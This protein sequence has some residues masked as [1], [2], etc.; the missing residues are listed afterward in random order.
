MLNKIIKYFRER[1]IQS[2]IYAATLIITFSLTIVFFIWSLIFLVKL[3][4]SVVISSD[5][6]S[7]IISVFNFVD[8]AALSQKLKIVLPEEATT[9]I[10]PIEPVPEV[11]PQA[12]STPSTSTPSIS[13]MVKIPIEE[14]SLQILN[15]TYTKGLAKLWQEKFI[16]AGFKNIMAENAEARD[17]K[18]AE[19]SYKPSKA[20]VLEK[21]TEVLISNGISDNHIVKKEGTEKLEYDFIIIIGQ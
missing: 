20:S 1:R 9:P 10:Q 15:G 16:N 12:T 7:S 21:I 14:I 11:L 2:I 17:Y 18:G 3:I 5:E 6:E 4:N 19:I 8:L 13:T